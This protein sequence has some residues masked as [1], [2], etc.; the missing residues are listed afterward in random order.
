MSDSFI[1]YSI[2]VDDAMHLIV[3][4]SLQ[5]FAESEYHGEHHFFVSFV[6][7]Y[8][9]VVLS[10]RLRS[11]YPHE[12]TIILQYMYDDLTVNDDS[13]S[14]SLSFDHVQTRIVIPFAALTAFADPSVKFGLQFRHSED[15]QNED[16][17]RI[18]TTVITSAKNKDASDVKIKNTKSVKADKNNNIIKLDFRNKTRI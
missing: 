6:T 4:K 17:K 9:G 12:M 13:F 11:K 8:P 3:K 5:V 14:V 18:S 10:D 1:D 15:E 7:K 2:L 16:G